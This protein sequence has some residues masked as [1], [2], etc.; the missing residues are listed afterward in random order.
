MM[1]N[2]IYDLAHTTSPDPCLP[3]IKVA[4][5]IPYDNN[6]G[7]STHQIEVVLELNTDYLVLVRGPYGRLRRRLGMYYSVLSG[8]GLIPSAGR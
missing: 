5:I 8:S 1:P 7:G 3:P 2:P 4:R 6:I